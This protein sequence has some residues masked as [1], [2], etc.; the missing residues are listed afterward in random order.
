[1]ENDN[2]GNLL[3][4]VTQTAENSNTEQIVY[5]DIGELETNPRNFYGLWTKC[6]KIYFG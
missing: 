3:S 4:E 5:I 2:L 6:D 1:M